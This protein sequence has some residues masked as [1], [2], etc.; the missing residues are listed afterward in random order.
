MKKN[1]RIIA[2]FFVLFVFVVGMVIGANL[3][4][5]TPT[6]SEYKLGFDDGY[7]YAVK[8]ARLTEDDGTHR[9]R[10]DRIHVQILIQF[11]KQL[12]YAGRFLRMRQKRIL[13][14]IG[15]HVAAGNADKVTVGDE[16]ARALQD[17]DELVLHI[18]H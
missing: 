8:T 4:S 15:V 13:V 6:T 1:D 2:W 5:N 17:S 11:R 18:R 7:D 14:H 12:P 3:P 9:R 10:N 16:G